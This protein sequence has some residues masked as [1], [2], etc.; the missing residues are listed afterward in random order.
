MARFIIDKADKDSAP[1]YE[2]APVCVEK[3][4]ESRW[5]GDVYAVEINTL[6]EMMKL[7]DWSYDDLNSWGVVISKDGDHYEMT[8]YNGYIE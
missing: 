1:Y 2:D 7:I 8:V 3:I 6:D 4:G 5:G